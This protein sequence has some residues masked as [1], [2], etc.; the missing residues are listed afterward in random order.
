MKKY[1]QVPLDEV[2]PD[3]NQPRKAFD[4]KSITNLAKS[5]A[6]EGLIHPIEVDSAYMIIVGEMRYRAAKLLKWQEITAIVNNDAIPPYE[7]LRRQMAENLQQSG[8]KGGGQAMNTIDTARAW[9]R[10]YKLKTGK[11]YVA[12]TQSYN[13]DG[14]PGP[15]LEI[16]HEVGVDKHTV[17]A[18]LKLLTEPKYVIDDLLK[19][20]S[21]TY[22][23]DARKAPIEVREQIKKK[24][25]KGQYNTRDEIRQE[26]ALLKSEPDLAVA[27]L[28]RNKAKEGPKINR[29]LNKIV[30]DRKS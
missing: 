26:T 10:L 14:M 17:W 25:S 24:I 27:E 6:V 4:E 3:P 8:A 28:Q 5:L 21:R 13:I 20:R 16:A 22:Y 9:A 12:A 18:Y 11:G 19:G 7:R 30:E 15:L 23:E 1:Q 2:K 29:I